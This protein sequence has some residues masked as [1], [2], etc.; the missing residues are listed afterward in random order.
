MS[1]LIWLFIIPIIILGWLISRYFVT[2]KTQQTEK[3]QQVVKDIKYRQV[4]EKSK[5]SRA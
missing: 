4:L 1:H 2:Q 5:T 3:Q